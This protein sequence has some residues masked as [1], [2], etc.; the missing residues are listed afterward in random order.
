MTNEYK[1]SYEETK[2]ISPDP[3]RWRMYKG[4]G[5]KYSDGMQEYYLTDFQEASIAKIDSIMNILAK[6]YKLQKFDCLAN[7]FEE[8]M[9]R[10]IY[11]FVTSGHSLPLGLKTELSKNNIEVEED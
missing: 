8:D 10:I 11:T 1:V 4:W 7:D 6:K 2:I 5:L 9:Y 3:V